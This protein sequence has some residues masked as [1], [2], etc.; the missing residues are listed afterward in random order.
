MFMQLQ[1]LM[2]YLYYMQLFLSE[3]RKEKKEKKRKETKPFWLVILQLTAETHRILLHFQE[4]SV[5]FK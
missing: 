5:K 4:F 3:E 1:M 2:I